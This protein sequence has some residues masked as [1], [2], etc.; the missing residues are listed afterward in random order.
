[1]EK[2]KLKL[3]QIDIYTTKNINKDILQASKPVT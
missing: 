2:S 3:T 1:M